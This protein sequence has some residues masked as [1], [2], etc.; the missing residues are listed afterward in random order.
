MDKGCLYVVAMPIGNRD[1]ITE[2]AKQI[3]ASVD[4]IAAEDTRHSRPLL[5]FLG[6]DTPLL[7]LHEHNEQKRMGSLIEQLTAGGTIALISDAGTPLIS[8][9]GFPLVRACQQADIRVVPIPGPSA[10]VCAL[11]AAGLPT[12]RFLFEG[13]PAKTGAARREQFT[14]LKD[15]EMTLIFYESSH[16]ISDCLTDMAQVFGE[17]RPAVVARELT[18]LHETILSYPLG[19][20]VEVLSKDPHQQKGEFVV[21]VAGAVRNED[22]I[23]PE[24]QRILSL[25][26]EELPTKQ[27]AVL[28]SR[29]TGAKKNRLYQVA[30]E[31]AEKE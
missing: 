19:Q 31:L 8:D 10:L 9:P 20:L 27:A 22:A 4:V 15:A 21:L 6:I 5:Q 16:R 30:L 11:S 3:L 17:E 7:A 12:D 18:K 2:R 25:L 13:F 23:E 26:L 1:D 28:A 24:T 29:I 14:R